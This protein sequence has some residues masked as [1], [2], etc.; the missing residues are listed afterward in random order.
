MTAPDP[1][2]D[3]PNSATKVF[4]TPCS[5]GDEGAIEKTWSDV[6]GAE[7]LEPVLKMADFLRSVKAVKASVSVEDVKKQ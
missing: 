1:L 5:P 6:E 2:S 3:P 4:L 7:L